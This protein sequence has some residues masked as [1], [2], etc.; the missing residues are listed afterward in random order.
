MSN[1]TQKKKRFF[2]EKLNTKKKSKIIIDGS[3]YSGFLGEISGDIL[4]K[5]SRNLWN[6]FCQ[7]FLTFI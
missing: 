4:D 3:R 6:D 7:Y 1:N 2:L 5:F